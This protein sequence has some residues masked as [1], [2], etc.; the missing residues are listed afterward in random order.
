MASTSDSHACDRELKSRWHLLSLLFS[1]RN[2]KIVENGQPFLSVYISGS[3]PTLPKIA[4]AFPFLDKKWSKQ[5]F[6]WC[7]MN[8]ISRLHASCKKGPSLWRPSKDSDHQCAHCTAR[9]S[10]VETRLLPLA[11]RARPLPVTIC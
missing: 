4:S 11:P 2:T 8:L 1:R 6:C 10:G 9:G 5:A 7:I 3:I